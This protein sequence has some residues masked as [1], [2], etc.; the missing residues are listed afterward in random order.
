MIQQ[1]ILLIVITV[2]LVLRCPSSVLAE[3]SEP[4]HSR[5]TPQ[6]TERSNETSTPFAKAMKASMTRMMTDMH[7]PDMSGNPDVDFLAMM[8][9]HHTGAVE[10]AR[11]VL[12]Y[13]IDPLVR[14]LAEEMIASQQV[15]ITA[16]QTRLPAL[17]KGADP[18]PEGFPAIHGT[19]G[20]GTPY[21]TLK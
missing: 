9:P 1:I 4:S 20:K 17:K 5:H 6:M 14:Q 15:E 2:L 19:R 8:I 16:M 7:Q 11:L 10:M 13:G 18:D 21:S 12:L 3:Q